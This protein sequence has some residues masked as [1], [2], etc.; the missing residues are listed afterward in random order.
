MTLRASEPSSKI[1]AKACMDVLKDG[2]KE[3]NL[4][5]KALVTK[6]SDGDMEF[7]E[8]R[9]AA[10]RYCMDV[11]K[12]GLKEH[13]LKPSDLASTYGVT[14]NEFKGWMADGTLPFDVFLDICK[15]QKI[16]VSE[17]FQKATDAMRTD[18]RKDELKSVPAPKTPDVDVLRHWFDGDMPF[19][20]FLEISGVSKIKA[21]D[22]FEKA[23]ALLKAEASGDGSGAGTG[24]GASTEAPFDKTYVKEDDGHAPKA[25]VDPWTDEAEARFPEGDG[26]EVGSGVDDTDAGS[27]NQGNVTSRGDTGV[28]GDGDS[29]K[30]GNAAQEHGTSS[31]DLLGEWDD[32]APS[33]PVTSS[34]SD[35]PSGQDGRH[36]ASDAS[37]PGSGGSG[38]TGSGVRSAFTGVG[39][40]SD[41][42]AAPEAVE[43]EV[44]PGVTEVD[45]STPIAVPYKINLTGKD[46]GMKDVDVVMLNWP[47]LRKK[48]IDLHDPLDGEERE[49]VEAR[50]PAP[51]KV[52]NEIVGLKFPKDGGFDSFVSEGYMRE[53][54]EAI[55]R[56]GLVVT[57]QQSNF[58]PLE[59]GI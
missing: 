20:W 55:D 51:V 57:L 14:I 56:E 42:G 50:W 10:A 13:D 46:S 54:Q 25:G 28:S 2:L 37:S 30:T 22:V 16:K 48:A 7:N 3:Q 15:K 29:G 19:V 43:K 5:P 59:R 21:N 9:L 1:R 23:K 38:G 40:Q 41:G 53:L 31:D 17:V 33:G 58:K 24:D 27:D 4:N 18:K 47:T 6:L 36:G 52:S 44:A 39:D 11:L 32:E 35:P 26:A 8:T 45:M 34:E 49:A 12:D